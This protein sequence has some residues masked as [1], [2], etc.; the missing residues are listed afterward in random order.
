VQN[1]ACRTL[2]AW[3]L[4][5]SLAGAALAAPAAPAVAPPSPLIEA[6]GRATIYHGDLA[7]ARQRAIEAALL[8][9]LERY[10]GLRIEA[11]TL[12][13]QG[14]LIDREVR[15]HTRGFVE[16]YE[17]TAERTEGNEQVVDVQLKVAA[18]PVDEALRRLLPATTTLLLVRESNLGQPVAG[19]AL[20]SALA[21]PFLG[22]RLLLLAGEPLER[23]T[24]ATPASYLAAPDPE[25]T[26]ELGLRW[27]SGLLVVA[28]ASTRQLDS[29]PGSLG[30]AVDAAALRPVVAASGHLAILAA[31]T[32]ESIAT[33][34]FDD[35][36]GSD[37]TSAERAGTAALRQLGDE[38]HRFLV[39]ALGRYIQTVGYPLRVEIRGAAA[40]EGGRRVRQILEATRWIESV[41]LE[42][43]EPSLTV[44]RASCREKPVYV[45]EELRQSPEITIERFDAL[46]GQLELR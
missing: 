22:A 26:R 24:A 21:P 15:S 27:M 35:V 8:R 10:A 3:A 13:R 40:G 16:S 45:V 4:A 31:A 25:S 39:E 36:R 38:M 42:R 12:I 28:E 6:S 29:G 33:R 46:A 44:L 19:T 32:G 30:Y 37:A 18:V 23:A 1:A 14:E 41:E 34:R 5:L 2:L 17:V 20:A 9:G 7:G 11:R 43:E